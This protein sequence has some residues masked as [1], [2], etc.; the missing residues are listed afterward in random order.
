MGRLSRY[1]KV[2]QFSLSGKKTSS[3]KIYEHNKN[4]EYIWGTYTGQKVKAKSLTV[5]NQQKKRMKKKLKGKKEY[6][7]DIAYKNVNFFD[8][9]PEK[10]DFDIRDILG[11]LKK[12]IPEPKINFGIN[13]S[14]K[15]SLASSFS[16][17]SLLT[18]HAETS[19]SIYKTAL[20][21]SY[22][23]PILN[24]Q[25]HLLYNQIHRE[26]ICL[27]DNR[28][29]ITG[30][31][32]GESMNAFRRRMK[33]ETKLAIML[34]VHANEAR[35]TNPEKKTR[36]AKFLKKRRNLNNKRKSLCNWCDEMSRKKEYLSS[37]VDIGPRNGRTNMGRSCSA[38]QDPLNKPP[39]IGIYTTGLRRKKYYENFKENKSL[40]V[41]R[42]L[43][44]ARIKAQEMYAM[45]KAKRKNN[46]F[47]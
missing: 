4:E 1:R 30:L 29:S 8:I 32:V 10:D 17:S 13:N 24:A 19:S 39:N 3:E 15:V 40:N 9:P 34:D 28:K 16:S 2:K 14:S 42:S 20:Q 44:H 38:L 18:N 6:S 26:Q 27:K 21:T 36:R 35:R 5:L 22:K 33:E 31:A 25:E 41:D 11:S 45:L 46:S 37:D 23:T 43:I 7:S 12:E 47:E